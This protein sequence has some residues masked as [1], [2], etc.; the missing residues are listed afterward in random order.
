MT[1]RQKKSGYLDFDP[2]TLQDLRETIS[3]GLTAREQKSP[4]GKADKAQIKL[5]LPEPLRARVENEAKE[6]GYSLN[7]EIIRRLDQSYK[8][9]DLG[10]VLFGDGDIFHCAYIF[11]GII[12]ALERHTGE[13]VRE[14]SS[15]FEMAVE[16][17]KDF[18]KVVPNGGMMGIGRML[19][20]TRDIFDVA[21][22][23]ALEQR[24]EKATENA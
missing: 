11:A 12:Q 22:V 10:T 17:L 3:A 15:I 8:D 7:S 18:A 21:A 6:I 23:R 14:D 4:R 5:R 16:Q 2:E 13:R 24:G 20:G 9:E 19:G 1:G